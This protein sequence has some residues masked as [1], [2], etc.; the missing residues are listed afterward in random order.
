MHWML[1]KVELSAYRQNTQRK[2]TVC[3]E[4]DA[5]ITVFKYREE[6]TTGHRK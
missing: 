4:A 5:V 6:F 3:T 1:H 2:G